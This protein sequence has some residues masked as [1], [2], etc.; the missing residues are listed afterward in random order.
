MVINIRDYLI[1]QML[2]LSTKPAVGAG[3]EIQT[4]RATDN[5]TPRF[6]GHLCYLS[7]VYPEDSRV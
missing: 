2:S 1:R 5:R 4:G 7:F 6:Y 3:E